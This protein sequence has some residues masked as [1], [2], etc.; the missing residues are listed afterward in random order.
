MYFFI[1]NSPEEKPTKLWHRYCGKICAGRRS[2]AE[3]IKNEWNAAHKDFMHDSATLALGG[4][5]E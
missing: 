1:L 4:R 3:R 5:F 2:G